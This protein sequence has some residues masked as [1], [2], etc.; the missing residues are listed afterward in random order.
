M[1]GQP[2]RTPAIALNLDAA[3]R[4]VGTVDPSF[5]VIAVSE[6]GDGVKSDVWLA[7][8]DGGRR[9]ALK[10]FKPKYAN[11]ADVEVAFY[12]T[13]TQAGRGELAGV[14]R[15][16]GSVDDGALFERR[17]VVM[18]AMPGRPVSEIAMLTD[19]EH[20][21]AYRQLGIV[22]KDL[23]VVEMSMFCGLPLDH[24]A[25]RPTGNRD[26]MTR[27]WAAAL[28]SY[29]ALG[30]NN[31][32]AHRVRDYLLERDDLWDACG[33]PVLCHG[34]PH[35]ANVLGERGP[36]GEFGVSGL[37]DFELAAAADPMLDLAVVHFKA[38]GDVEAKFAAFLDGYG[39][40]R[41]EWR[42][43]LDAYLLYL[44]LELWTWYA[45]HGSRRPLRGIDRR[46]ATLTGTSRW[47]MTR[48]AARARLQSG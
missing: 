17:V 37:I 18:S 29:W 31:Y 1:A 30:G 28:D 11:F 39:P 42:D 36:S 25:G 10:T 38:T 3:Q 24:S 27:R 46:I 43:H 22:L 41:F 47:R 14:P 23:H 8:C 21:L 20:A 13:L 35:M 34:D 32:L 15:F 5:D 6:L 7:E 2:D 4:I 16:I 26:Y 33:G 44:L 12:R 40:L 45:S 19:D 9:L 48:S